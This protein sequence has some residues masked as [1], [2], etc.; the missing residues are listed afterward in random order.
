MKNG[1]EKDIY[2]LLGISFD[3]SDEKIK[4]A[5]RKLAIKYHPDVNKDEKSVE[6]F[7]E[8]SKAYELLSDKQRRRQYDA[9]MGYYN[10]PRPKTAQPEKPKAKGKPPSQPSQGNDKT[11][12]FNKVFNDIFEGIFASQSK[13]HP[14]KPP[15][16]GTDVITDIKITSSEAISGVQRTVN[17]LHTSECPNCEGRKFINGAKCPV[18]KGKG[19]LSLHKKISVK[20]PAGV[21][22]KQKIKI[23]NEGNKGYYGGKNGDLYLLIEVEQNSLFKFDGNNTILEVAITPYEATLGATIDIPTLEGRV[24]MKIPPGTGSSQKFKLT[25]QGVY[26]PA[27]KKRGDQIVT[28]KIESN[29]NPSEEEK[30]LYEKIRLCSKQEIRKDLFRGI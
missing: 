23:P 27:T 21:K 28:I 17:I 8:I 10:R 3:A 20:I 14:K 29:K 22:S 9:M 19:E 5:Y 30:Q 24:S 26:D 4:S 13:N 16:D 18:C 11:D 12:K 15:A 1:Q 2:T 25:E 6:K 7:K